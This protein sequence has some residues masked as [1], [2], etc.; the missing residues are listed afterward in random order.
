MRTKLRQALLFAI[1]FLCCKGSYAQA[2]AASGPSA[3]DLSSV[4]PTLTTSFNGSVAFQSNVYD[5]T[6]T[7]SYVFDD[8]FSASIGVPIVFVHGTSSTGTTTSNAGLG[9]IFGRLQ[10]T[11]KNPLLNFG[12]LTTVALPTGDSSKGLSTGRVTADFTGQIAK[13]LGRFTPFLSAG[14]G[15]SL[16]D[17]ASWQRPYTTLGD[18]AHFQ[19]GSTF[20]L[21]RSL[22]LSASLYD[23]APW[24][25][26]K[27]YSRVIAKG[28]TSGPAASKHGRVFLDNAVSTGGSSI[29]SDNGFNADLNF[30]PTKFVDVDFAYLHSVYFETDVFSFGVGVNLSSLLRRGAVSRN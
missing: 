1:V 12:A 5:W 7:A 22:T 9:S 20:A 13:P 4:G 17:T 14:V 16:F 23:V 26:Q 2:P 30:A 27:L 10:F 15:N 6:T 8:H 11:A 19:G 24:G 29:D 28:V 25:D 3:S 18:V 21:G